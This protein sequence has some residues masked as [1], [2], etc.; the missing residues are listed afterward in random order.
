[1]AWAQKNTGIPRNKINL[2]MRSQ[3]KNFANASSILID[4]YDKNTNEFNRAGGT[5]ITFK[6]ASQT[7]SELKKLGF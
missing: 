7:I 2:V 5:G 6:S 3:K 4:D 1:M